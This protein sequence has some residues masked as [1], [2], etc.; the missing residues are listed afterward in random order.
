MIL[1]G[2]PSPHYAWDPDSLLRQIERVCDGGRQ[3]QLS[4]SRRTPQTFLRALRDRQLPGLEL[5]DAA[6]LPPGWLAE[7]LPQ[8]QAC[9]VTPD[10]ASMVYEALTAGCAVGLFDLAAQPGSRVA[11]AVSNL[12]HRNLATPFSRFSGGSEL[13]LPP[14][15]FAEADRCAKRILERGWV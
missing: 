12:I 11:G 7:R 8:M 4:G 1:I 6:S 9:W 2:G 3:W 15:P 13:K 14:T 10:S 5:H